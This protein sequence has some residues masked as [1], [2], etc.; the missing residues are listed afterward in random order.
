MMTPGFAKSRKELFWLPYPESNRVIINAHNFSGWTPSQIATVL[1]LDAA[2][3]STLFDAVSG[4]SLVA[5]DGAIARWQDKSGNARHATQGTSGSRPMRKTL[6]QNS[7]DAV[8]FDGTDDWLDYATSVFTYTGASSVFAVVKST[9]ASANEYGSVIAEYNGSATSIGCQTNV[10]PAG[11]F[12]PATDCFSPGGMRYST[13]GTASNCNVI[14]WAW[15]NWSTHKTSG[16]ILTLN[17][18]EETGIAYGA[19]PTGFTSTA[20]SI[21]RFQNVAGVTLNHLGMD[22]CELFV[23]QSLLSESDRQK[24]VGY[25][26]HKWG[27]TSSLPSGHPYKTVAP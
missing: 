26:A 15:Q 10:F 5:A 18:S 22:L 13:T 7:R 12:R 2:D 4:G 3:S 6:V 14:G 8:R 1:W 21:G 23:V 20:R 19:T 9:S 25:L 16:T 17:G 24:A 11:E 27:T